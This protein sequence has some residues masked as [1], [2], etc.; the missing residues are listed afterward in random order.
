MT[1]EKRAVL[2]RPSCKPVPLHDPEE[3][4]TDTA[5]FSMLAASRRTRLS[6]SQRLPDEPVLHAGGQLG[7]WHI[8]GLQAVA[9]SDRLE[10]AGASGKWLRQW[11]G[12]GSHF[13]LH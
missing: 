11:E 1:L 2:L 10:S 3:A 8:A 12:V 6:Q 4:S 9:C 13:V 7:R 5:R